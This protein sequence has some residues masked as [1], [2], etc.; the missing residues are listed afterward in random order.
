MFAD[1]PSRTTHNGRRIHF[2]GDSV[3]TVMHAC[4]LSDRSRRG[5]ADVVQMFLVPVADYPEHENAVS[6][7]VSQRFIATRRGVDAIA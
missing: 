5:Y 2:Q 1:N 7:V 3:W 6:A 4:P